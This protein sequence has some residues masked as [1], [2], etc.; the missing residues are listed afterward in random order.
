M[1]AT[2]SSRAQRNAQR[3]APAPGQ[4]RALRGSAVL[5]GVLALLAVH[6]GLVVVPWARHEPGTA[7]FAGWPQP[8]ETLGTAAFVLV[9]FALALAA[10]ASV[11]A[12]A[13][14]RHRLSR[15]ERAAHV[16]ALVAAAA[17]PVWLT[18]PAGRALVE[19]WSR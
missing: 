8:L 14:D 12:L 10:L 15:L 5:A 1:V 11:R 18:S 13:V 7:M 3:R 2:A 6:A 4:E 16:L 9:P 19:W 17:L